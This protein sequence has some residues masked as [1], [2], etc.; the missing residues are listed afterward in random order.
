MDCRNE[1]DDMVTIN[2]NTIHRVDNRPGDHKISDC[3]GYG[4]Y[5]PRCTVCDF[6]GLCQLTEHERHELSRQSGVTDAT[7]AS[8]ERVKQALR[9]RKDQK[10]GYWGFRGAI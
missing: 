2:G 4:H 5:Q 8:V 7:R 10:S 3:K 9:D 1:R 6:D